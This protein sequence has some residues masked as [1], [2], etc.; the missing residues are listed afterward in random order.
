MS[1]LLRVTAVAAVAA[2]TLLPAAPASACHEVVAPI[3]VDTPAGRIDVFPG[4]Y[5]PC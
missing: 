3:Y 2:V 1:R 4:I 5:I